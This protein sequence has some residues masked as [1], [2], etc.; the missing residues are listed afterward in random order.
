MDRAP[1]RTPRWRGV[2]LLHEMRARGIAVA[3]ASD[4][5]RDPFH[6]YG[7]L[8]MQE[9]LRLSVRIAHLEHPLADWP[10][11]ASAWPSAICGY[12]DAGRIAVGASADLVLFEGRSWSEVLARPESRRTVLRAGRAI[13]TT[14]PAYAELDLLFA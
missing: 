11:L 10:A 12:S 2:T 3:V 5:T 7:D 8:D 13:D 6:A 14:L 1:A 9:V 4:N